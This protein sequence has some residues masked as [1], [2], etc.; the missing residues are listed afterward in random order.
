MKQAD[1]MNAAQCIIVGRELTDSQ[2]LVIKDMK[3]GKQQLV[4]V[5]T[6]LKK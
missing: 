2:Q 3:T 6:F 4:A 5:E 1:A